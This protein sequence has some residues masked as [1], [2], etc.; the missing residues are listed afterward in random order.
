VPGLSLPRLGTLVY[1]D[2][3]TRDAIYECGEASLGLPYEVFL[4]K[5]L[6]YLAQS[7]VANVVGNLVSSVDARFEF[8]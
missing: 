2:R 5:K 6:A 3:F 1:V 4:R 8:P 7:V